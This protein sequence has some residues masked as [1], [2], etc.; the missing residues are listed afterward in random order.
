MDRLTAPVRAT[1]QRVVVPFLVLL[2]MMF[3][4]LGKADVLL[5][6]RLRVAVA[7]AAAPAA[8][9]G[10]PADGDRRLGRAPCRGLFDLYRENERLREE[11]ARLLQWQDVARRLEDENAELRGLHEI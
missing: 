10:R 7:D 11:N 9:G 8:A 3:I 6:D 4:V 5:F 2:S 1:A